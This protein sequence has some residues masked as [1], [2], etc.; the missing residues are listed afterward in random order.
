MEPTRAQEVVAAA[1][2]WFFYLRRK[3][4]AASF[5]KMQRAQNN[6]PVVIFHYMEFWGPPVWWHCVSMHLVELS[7]AT[8]RLFIFCS[9]T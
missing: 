1:R 3:L 8:T 9:P 6:S 7:Q 2:A 4:V 5:R